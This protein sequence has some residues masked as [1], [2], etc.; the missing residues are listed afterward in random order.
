[1]SFSEHTV[2]TPA[3][4]K[5]LVEDVIQPCV[6]PLGFMGH[7]GYR[8]WGPDDPDNQYEGWQLCVYP[9][10]SEIRGQAADD[11]GMYVAGFRFDVSRLITGLTDVDD[12]VWASPARYT[13]NLDGPEIS[14]RGAFAGKRVWVRFFCMPPPDEPPSF[15]VDPSTGEATELPA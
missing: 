15:Q 4:I 9:T 13:S 3:W 14:V 12:V 6:L 1:M 8:Y 2:E 11:G 5:A 10:P 7:L